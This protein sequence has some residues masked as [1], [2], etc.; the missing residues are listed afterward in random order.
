MTSRLSPWGG[1]LGWLKRLPG[2]FKLPPLNWWR[3]YW[4][5][6]PRR[7]KP[8]YRKLSQ[9]ERRLFWLGCLMMFSGIAYLGLERIFTKPV[10]APITGAIWRESVVGEISRPLP[11]LEVTSL[12]KTI[13][14]LIFKPILRPDA[15]GNLQPD[16]AE[17][18]SHDSVHQAYTVTLKPDQKWS[19]GQPVTSDD[20][21]QTV[22]LWQKEGISNT[23]SVWKEVKAETKD[24]RTVIFSLSRSYALFPYLLT[25]GFL[26]SH[27][28]LTEEQK[29][30][31]GDSA[32]VYTPSKAT[33]KSLRFERRG[34]KPNNFSAIELNVVPDQETALGDLNRDRAKAV[35][36]P[37]VVDAK[38]FPK[39]AALE[40]SDDLAVLFSFDQPELK[41]QTIRQTLRDKRATPRPLNLSLIYPKQPDMQARADE[42][43]KQWAT[44]DVTLRLEGL[45]AAAYTD[46]LQKGTFDTALV[47]LPAFWLIDP[48]VFLHSSQAKP[49]GFNW[50]RV[51]DKQLDALVADLRQNFGPGED[52]AKRDELA[53]KLN[54]LVPYISLGHVQSAYVLAPDKGGQS[55]EFKPTGLLN[56]DDRLTAVADSAQ[57]LREKRI[58]K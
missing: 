10:Y 58:K 49:D 8:V 20:V 42:L 21:V 30:L 6:I 40:Q 9:S 53:K 27:I 56:A 55:V 50:A 29:T 36:L 57:I 1:S 38:S 13:S 41:Q 32:F 48:Y 14:H 19:D 35:W 4:R 28:P 34:D 12:D 31:V 24:D 17:S 16:A 51:K 15:S 45:D 47:K 54:D 39:T 23:S 44:Q 37:N 11:G 46:R 25:N 3:R 18:I 33:P 26:P 2:W 5:T 43:S 7:L 52:A 22:S